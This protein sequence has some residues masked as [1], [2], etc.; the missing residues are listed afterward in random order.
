M[1]RNGWVCFWIVLLHISIFHIM[2]YIIL[3]CKISAF[4]KWMLFLVKL[5][6]VAGTKHLTYGTNCN[7][8]FQF[9]TLCPFL[10]HKIK[11]EQQNRFVFINFSQLSDE[12]NQLYRSTNLVFN[13]T[14]GF[15]NQ[16]FKK[17]ILVTSRHFTLMWSQI[18]KDRIYGLVL[19]MKF[20]F[21]L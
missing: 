15:K 2:L 9:F 11:K 17:V 6:C 5:F 14:K 16:G 1:G 10:R 8:H 18:L 20:N 19:Y 7:G 4:R 13:I 12:I 3:L 21:S